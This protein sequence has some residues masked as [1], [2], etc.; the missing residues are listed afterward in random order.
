MNEPRGSLRT[1]VD[2]SIEIDVEIVY[3]SELLVSVAERQR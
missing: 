1:V 3:A 2:D